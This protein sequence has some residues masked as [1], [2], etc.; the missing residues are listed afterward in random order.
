MS[1]ISLPDSVATLAILRLRL[2][3]GGHVYA[4]PCEA[5]YADEVMGVSDGGIVRFGYVR[6]YRNGQIKL[7]N[8]QGQSGWFN[9]QEVQL[10]RL[11]RLIDGSEE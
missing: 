9:S 8:L 10:L 1:V 3:S 6:P 4:I 5:I 11:V 2:L 7:I